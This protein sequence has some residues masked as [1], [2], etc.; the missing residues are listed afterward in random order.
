[1]VEMVQGLSLST[2]ATFGKS[3]VYGSIASWRKHYKLMKKTQITSATDRHYI[4]P[5]YVQSIF[6]TGNP[7][8]LRQRNL[9]VEA[10]WLFKG[11]DQGLDASSE[12]SESANE[13]ILIFFFQLD[14]ATRV[15][16]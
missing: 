5:Q 11:G 16:V 15:Q 3:G 6:L 4:W 8:I 9:R 10:G 14:L 1:M 7:N 2:L 12:R 13:D